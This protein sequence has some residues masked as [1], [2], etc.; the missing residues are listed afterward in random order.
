[1]TGAAPEEEE[2][3]DE[4]TPKKEK[5][6]RFQLTALL[7]FRKRLKFRCNKFNCEVS[8]DLSSD[9]CQKNFNAALGGEKTFATLTLFL[10]VVLIKLV[11]VTFVKI[12]ATFM[13][14]HK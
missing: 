13:F 9:T 6:L 12:L 10:K 3:E 7:A 8:S 11:N 14:R 1:M 5:K 4:E 2:E